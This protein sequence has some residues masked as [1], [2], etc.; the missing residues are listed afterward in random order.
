MV[1]GAA[2][3]DALGAPFEFKSPGLYRETFPE[4]VQTGL[5]EMIGGGAFDWEPGEFT[6]DTQMALALA[7]SIIEFGD[8]D[9][10]ATWR[11]FRAWAET[12]A[13]IG[14][15][16]SWSL[17]HDDWRD[18]SG[19][20]RDSASNGALM[21]SFVLAALLHGR[22]HDIA[23]EIVLAQ[24]SLTHPHP[25]SG[26]GAWIA[27]E[28]CRAFIAGDDGV[29]MIDE[30]IAQVPDDERFEKMLS[31]DWAPLP[32]RISNGSVWGCLAEAVWAV[33][34]TSSYEEAVVAAVNLGDDADTVGCVAGALAGARYGFDSIPQRWQRAVHG[35]LDG[36]DGPYTY[37]AQDLERI[38]LQ[39][40]ALTDTP[41]G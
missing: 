22:P 10:D 25:A 18:V 37:T 2:V 24:S 16:T 19:H 9:S 23:Q 17:S 7:E 12:A 39:L 21:R 8:Y 35:R 28:M 33:R 15:T 13:D 26:W 11:W 6:D 32:K 29:A 31:E 1:V 27:V 34:T 36:P 3:G 4:A 40:L 20:P 41:T 14:T 30:L 38:T 5:C